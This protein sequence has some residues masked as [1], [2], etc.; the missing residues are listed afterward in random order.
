M[1]D[2]ALQNESSRPKRA[3]QPRKRPGGSPS[4]K[5][6][7]VTSVLALERR[8]EGLLVLLGRLLP[9]LI[10]DLPAPRRARAEAVLRVVFEQNHQTKSPMKLERTEAGEY[11]YR[12]LEKP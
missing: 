8:Y 5:P 6:K 12:Q 2:D 1:T 3:A 4:P 10:A 11:L 9:N 7:Q